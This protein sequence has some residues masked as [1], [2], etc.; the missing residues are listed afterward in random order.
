MNDAKIIFNVNRCSWWHHLSNG[1]WGW[2]SDIIYD[3][4]HNK[5]AT[6]DL[7]TAYEYQ[8]RDS[9]LSKPCVAFFHQVILGYV[10]SLENL[11]AHE[12]WQHNIKMISGAVT[13]CEEQKNFLQEHGLS[14]VTCIPHPTPLDVPTWQQSEFK[15]TILHVGVHCRELEFLSQL[16][17]ESVGNFNYKYLAAKD[18]VPNQLS[19]RINILKRVTDQKFNNLLVSSVIFLQLKSATANNTVLECIAR[20]TPVIV[21]PIGGIPEYL[22]KDYPLYY[23]G[24]ENAKDLI[25][26]IREDPDILIDTHNYLMNIRERFSKDKFIQ[27]LN[28]IFKKWFYDK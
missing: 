4:Y 8:I 28:E 15:D 7:F 27:G 13:V 3:N 14:N 6:T 2:V 16:A 23:N 5:S 12:T 10:R 21:N 9:K 24:L 20:G 11:V 18:D 1:G 26:S 17:D 19:N 22:G 25:K